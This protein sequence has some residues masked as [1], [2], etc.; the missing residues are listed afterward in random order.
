MSAP[1]LV[2]IFRG[3][4]GNKAAH[5][6]IAARAADDDLVLHHKRRRSRAD[7]LLFVGEFPAEQ[8][9]ARLAV[10]RDQVVVAGRKVDRVAK[11]RRPTVDTLIFRTGVD[12]LP[13]LAPDRASSA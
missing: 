5:S 11:D 9:C 4:G 3:Q 6:A 13:D 10:Q 2:T 12:V 8:Q 1:D 7:S